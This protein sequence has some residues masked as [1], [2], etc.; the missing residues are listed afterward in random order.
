MPVPLFSHYM[1]RRSRG[2]T[3]YDLFIVDTT[4]TQKNSFYNRTQALYTFYL[5][6]LFHQ[7]P[8]S[9]IAL[10]RLKSIKVMVIAQQIALL[11]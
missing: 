7:Q 5:S 1:R 4:I 11:R 8:L 9:T 10:I 6:A 2:K 3:E